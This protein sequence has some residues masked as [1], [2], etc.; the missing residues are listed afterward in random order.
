MH[1]AKLES[2]LKVYKRITGQKDIQSF[3]QWFKINKNAWK[4]LK[5]PCESSMQIKL[6]CT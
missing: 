4:Y 6:S 2:V 5:Q 1:T 3:G